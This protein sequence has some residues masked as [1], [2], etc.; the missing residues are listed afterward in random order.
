MMAAAEARFFRR[1]DG[2]VIAI[3]QKIGR[4]LQEFYGVRGQISVIPHG[5][6]EAL[7]ERDRQRLRAA[8]R[9][10]SAWRRRT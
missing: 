4:E 9:M 3:S 1:Y 2:R 8:V 10:N 5:V 7:P 6:R